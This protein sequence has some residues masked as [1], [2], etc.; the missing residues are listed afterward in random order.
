MKKKLSIIIIVSMLF[1]I[2]ATYLVIGTTTISDTGIVTTGTITSTGDNNLGNGVL[3]I[4]STS[5]FV[6]IGT[7]NPT[8]KLNVVGNTNITGFTKLGSDAPNIKFKKFNGTMVSGA[9]QTSFNSGINA[10]RVFDIS[11]RLTKTN[12]VM[13]FVG[14]TNTATAFNIQMNGVSVFIT[15]E[16]ANYQDKSYECLMTYEE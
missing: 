13:N 7:S 2:L 16:S 11:C 6:G 5:G 12:V 9:G 4:N 14:S 1:I 15:P 10:L 3:F 8:D